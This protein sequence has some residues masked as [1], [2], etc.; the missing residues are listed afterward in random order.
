MTQLA[1]LT[2][3]ALTVPTVSSVPVQIF[4]LFGRYSGIP[5]C[6]YTVSNSLHP[7]EIS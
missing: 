7:L 3:L 5:Q 1:L 4:N 6:P 2:L